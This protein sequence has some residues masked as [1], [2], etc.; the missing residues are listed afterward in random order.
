[1][2][3]FEDL[4]KLGANVIHEQTHIARAKLELVLNK[5]FADLNRVQ[6]MGFM[7]ILEREYGIDLSDIRHEYDEFM[8]T[9]P[10][11]MLPKSS[12]ILQ[13]ES[14]TRQK[15]VL[16]G[17]VAIAVLIALGSMTQ[18]RLSIS[19][20]DDIIKLS[21]ADVEI[22]DQNTDVITPA[23]MNTTVIAPVVE[24]NVS[25]VKHEQNTTVA[26]VKNIE[27]A[28][29]IKPIVKVWMGMMDMTTGQKTQKVTKDPVV[30]DV[31]KNTLFM[32]GHG[33]LEI[34]TAEGKKTL[35]DRNTVWFTFENGKL[36]Q[37]N[38]EQFTEINKGI[39]W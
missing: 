12:V 29:S 27:T 15:W 18:G 1:M 16:G 5:S 8:Q 39:N 20:S 36:Q 34:T 13:A 31:S 33:R 26:S 35:Q 38:E 32:F 10:D 28:I 14:R 9:H 2:N 37:I 25:V 7:S 21:S 23:E 22:V 19:P 4:Q 24:A 11:V 3:N 30:L 6:F 17:V